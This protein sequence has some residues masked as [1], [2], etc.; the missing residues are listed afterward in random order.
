LICW[1]S[2]DDVTEYGG[3]P[4]NPGRESIN[5]AG[6]KDGEGLYLFTN[7]GLKEALTGFDLNKS[8]YEAM[9]LAGILTRQKDGTWN[10]RE[11]LGGTQVRV[12]EVHLDE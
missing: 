10:K 11:R 4:I 5:R 12:Y 9:H 2:D 6:W 1:Q 3:F 7:G 8:T